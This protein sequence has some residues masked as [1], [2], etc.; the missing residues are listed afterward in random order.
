MLPEAGDGFMVIMLAA[1][2]LLG[3]D[4][5]DLFKIAP[6]IRKSGGGFLFFNWDP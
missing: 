5:T 6:A 4:D 1:S 2:P 3:K